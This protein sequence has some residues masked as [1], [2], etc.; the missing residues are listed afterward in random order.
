MK[1]QLE[2]AYDI[3]RVVT[4]ENELTALEREAHVLEA[5]EKSLKKVGGQLQEAIDELSGKGEIQQ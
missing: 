5:E 1:K 4:M 2:G 3:D